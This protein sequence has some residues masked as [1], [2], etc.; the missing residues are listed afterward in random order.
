MFESVVRLGE[1]HSKKKNQEPKTEK[2]EPLPKIC[3]AKKRAVFPAAAPA[4]H[5]C[6][7]QSAG[8]IGSSV[9]AA[10]DGNS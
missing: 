7:G 6:T 9:A 5:S 10:D 3:T 4:Q 8:A 2:N 1:G